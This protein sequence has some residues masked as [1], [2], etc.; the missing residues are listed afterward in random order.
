MKP[1]QERVLAEVAAH[2]D[3]EFTRADYETL[4]HVSRSQAAYDLVELVKLGL[5]ERFGSGRA[6]HYRVVRGGAGRRRKWT[7]ERIRTE[8]SAFCD[9]LGGWP[10][11]SEFKEAGRGDLYLAASRYGGIDHWAD[12]L[13]YYEDE[14]PE[15]SEPESGSGESELR[16][17]VPLAGTGLATLAA[18][19]F[20]SVAAHRQQPAGIGAEP[21]RGRPSRR[22]RRDRQAGRR[23]RRRTRQAWSPPAARRGK[24]R[25]LARGA[26]W[27]GRRAAPV[28]GDP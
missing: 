28:G 7:S 3:E 25:L 12:E 6:T 19:A 4:A 27:L 20:L 14:V 26:A 10:R 11:A 2:P 13:G 22:A 23:T 18:L 17:W 8:L 15:P 1:A 24:R 21:G 9:E 16:R 5:V